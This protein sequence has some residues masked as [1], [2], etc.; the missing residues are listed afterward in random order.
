MIWPEYRQMFF[1]HWT[2][3]QKVHVQKS[4]EVVR[5]LLHSRSVQRVKIIPTHIRRT[6][7]LY[8]RILV[9]DSHAF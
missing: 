1:Q 5:S 2:E 7:V 4:L 8:R 6:C 3:S 9:Q